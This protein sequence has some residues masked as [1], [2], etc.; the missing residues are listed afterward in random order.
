MNKD[1]K[2][3]ILQD[4]VRIK[5]VND[6]EEEVAVYIQNLLKEHGIESEFS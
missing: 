2:V 6:N 1:E 3:K 4:I 5:S